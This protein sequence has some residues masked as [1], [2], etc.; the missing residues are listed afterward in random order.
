MRPT[1]ALFLAALSCLLWPALVQAQTADIRWRSDYNASRKEA[2]RRGLPLVIEFVTDNCFWCRRLEQETFAEP[3]VARLM[4][5]RFV[6]LKVDAGKDAQLVQLLNIRAFPTIVLA[7]PDGKILGTVEGFQDAPKF[8]DNLQRTLAAVTNPEWMVRDYQMASRAVQEQDYGKAVA[9]LKAILDDGKS[10]PVQL[11]A[12]VLLKQVEQ[13]AYTEL[14]QAKTML[15]K[16]KTYEA[17][18]L[19]TKLVKDY[20]GTQA[21]PEAAGMLTS[22][23][24]TPEM[25]GQA[26]VLRAREL[27]AQAKEDFRTEQWL[28]CLDR[29]ELLSNG[30]GDMPEGAEAAQM[31]A[32]IRSN[33]DWMQKACDSMTVRL[34][35]MYLNLAE[36]WLQ[37]GQQ[38]QAMICLE[39]V[40]RAFPGTRQAD[41][42]Q[43]RL[44]QLR[45]LPTQRAGFH[46][47]IAPKN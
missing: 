35:E 24:R 10:R 27:L 46:D 16:G 3:A 40:V 31:A 37:R 18:A 23:S 28:C 20:A 25:K 9:L 14:A 44:A 8:H 1:T 36:S 6:A 2:E 33:A 43:F 41:A 34:G 47:A 32:T 13:Q 5:E 39:R 12:A 4:N 19:L 45:G 21:A 26:R 30:Y 17:S 42:A 29:C 38:Q 15:D 11:N 22:L 7:G